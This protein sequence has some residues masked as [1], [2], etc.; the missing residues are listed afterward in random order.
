MPK[1]SSLFSATRQALVLWG[2]AILLFIVGW[3]VAGM[4]L[5]IGLS[6]GF[7]ATIS[8]DSLGSYLIEALHPPVANIQQ[9]RQAGSQMAWTLMAIAGSF[10]LGFWYTYGGYGRMT[11]LAA[12]CCPFL[13]WRFAS[14]AQVAWVQARR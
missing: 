5:G 12:I 11:L 13:A 6:C 2:Q 10:G 1:F 4:G 14:Q 9:L 3:W 8:I 7:L